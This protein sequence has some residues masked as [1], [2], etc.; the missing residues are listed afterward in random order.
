[1]HVH[2]SNWIATAYEQCVS[3]CLGMDCVRVQTLFAHI[4]RMF[5]MAS[6]CKHSVGIPIGNTYTYMY[7]CSV[8]YVMQLFCPISIKVMLFFEIAYT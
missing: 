6:Q 1:M 8:Y 2:V 5:P 4:S 7:L 3:F